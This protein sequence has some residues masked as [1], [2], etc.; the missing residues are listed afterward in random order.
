MK[1]PAKN[2]RQKIKVWDLPTRVFHWLLA[3]SFAGAWLTADSER[4]RDLHLMF[5]Y[6]LAGLIG[7]RLLWGVVGTRYARFASFAFAPRRLRSYLGS[8]L[9]GAPEHHPGHNPA[10]ALA[11]FLLLALGL[12]T[13]AS[14]YASYAEV[15]GDWAEDLHEGSA[16]AML[17]VVAIHLVGVLVSSVFHRE[18]LVRAMLT[19]DK[20][21]QP[22][23]AIGGT[24]AGVAALVLVAVIG[25]WTADRSGWIGGDGQVHQASAATP[26][27]ALSAGVGKRG[28]RGHGHRRE[29]DDD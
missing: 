25:Y 6:T 3:L 8:L 18:N 14:G 21:G 27:T 10:G 13:V 19:G 17:A 4:W 24:R 5:G 9:G 15:G 12:I 2:E 22:D 20:R 23:Q 28:E 7:F 29:T 26:E 1:T 16:N 11:I